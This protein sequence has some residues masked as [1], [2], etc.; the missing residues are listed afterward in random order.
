MLASDLHV[1]LDGSMRDGTLVALAREAGVVPST[2]D[3][4]EFTRKLRFRPG[5]SLASCLGRF[6]VTVGLLQTRRALERVAC[7]LVCDC[8]RDGV[9][10][11]EVRFCPALHTREG[12][13]AEDAVGAVLAGLERGTGE[14]LAGAD[15]EW[16]SARAIVSVLEGMSEE[17]TGELVNLAVAFADSWVAGVDLAGDEALFDAARHARPFA[18]AADAGLGV[19][20]HAGEGGDATNVAAAVE[21]LG[22]GRIGHGVSAASDDGVMSLL[23]DR[24]VTVEVCLSSN[25]HTGAVPSL[26]EHPFVLLAE[27]GV[28]VALATDNTF[29]SSTTLS[30]EY[31]LAARAGAGADL[32]A[33]SVLASADA[34]FLPDEERAALRRLYA[35][36]L[37]PVRGP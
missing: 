13:S 34:A 8:Y 1:H 25:L 6:E 28:P 32:S 20:V 27:A 5:M 12:L 3:D 10:H 18:R 22:A 35:A 11:A 31:E 14:A 15:G 23:A 24:N 4:D 30:H 29:F 9:R 36:S 7:E 33:R 21:I 2:L 37:G 17:E 26:E 19:T 16:M